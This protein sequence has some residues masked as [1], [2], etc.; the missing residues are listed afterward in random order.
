MARSTQW[1]KAV[2]TAR[3]ATLKSFEGRMK[4]A[5]ASLVPVPHGN[6]KTEGT[7]AEFA[8]EAGVEYGTLVQYRTVWRWLGEDH[9]HVCVIRSYSLAYEAKKS[10]EWPTAKSFV[11]MI[12]KNPAPTLTL[13]GFEPHEF[14]QWTVD[15]LRVYLGKRPTNT[16]LIALE[17]AEGEKPTKDAVKAAEASDQFEEAAEQAEGIEDTKQSRVAKKAADEADK[18]VSDHHYENVIRD[19]DEGA[20]DDEFDRTRE[21]LDRDNLPSVIAERAARL[22]K[23]LAAVPQWIEA[24]GDKRTAA[25][26]PP[27]GDLMAA[28]LTEERGLTDMAFEQAGAGGN[29]GDERLAAEFPAS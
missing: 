9:A 6:S 23:A 28:T 13:D 22:R 4:A 8:E 14:T 16:G 11:S 3:L 18:K 21:L 20:E 7:L 27:L 19:L 12:E 5:E 2:K 1:K 24:F 29:L 26:T 25:D 10:G 15:A 17:E